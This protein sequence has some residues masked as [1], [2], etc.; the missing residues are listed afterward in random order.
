MPLL[1]VTQTTRALQPQSLF[2]SQQYATAVYQSELMYRLRRLGYEIE[3]GKSGAPEIKGYSQEYLDASSPRSQQIRAYMEQ[4]G[5]QGHLRPA[6]EHDGHA[7]LLQHAIGFFHRR[8]EPGVIGIVLNG[9]SIT[10]AVIHQIRRIGQD[11]IDAIR[12]HHPLFGYK[13]G[14]QDRGRHW[15]RASLILLLSAS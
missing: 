2:E 12:G 9:T 8:L 5:I 15:S 11:E 7:I 6:V 1:E 3:P 10:V 13:S 4:N 14:L